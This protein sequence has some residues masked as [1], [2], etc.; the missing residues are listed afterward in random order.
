MDEAAKL[1]Q[2]EGRPEGY[3][4]EKQ[5]QYYPKVFAWGSD[6]YAQ[7]LGVQADR[8]CCGVTRAIPVTIAQQIVC[9]PSNRVSTDALARAFSALGYEY[10]E[11]GGGYRLVQRSKEEREQRACSLAYEARYG[12]KSQADDDTET[13]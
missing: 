9:T 2:G 5:M 13:F 7:L 10:V 8:T 6:Y 11:N 12:I 4:L 1:I 3:Q